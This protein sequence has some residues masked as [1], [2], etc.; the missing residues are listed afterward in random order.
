MLQAFRKV[1]EVNV[2]LK[3]NIH[4]DEEK[5]KEKEKE[6]MTETER[7]YAYW[8]CSIPMIGGIRAGQ[9]LARFGSP[10]AVYEAGT[11]GWKEL[12]SD[13]IVE[14]MDTQKKNTSPIEEYQQMEK[15]QIRL[16]LQEEEGFPQK[17]KEIPDPPY[18][19]FYKGR[20]PQEKQPAVAIIGARECSEYGRFVAA[21][22]GQHLGREKIQVISGMA[23]GIDGISQQ[24]ALAA[25][26]MSFGVLGCGVDICYPAQNRELYEQLQQSGGVLSTYAPK[27]RPL[28]AYFP[29]R[30][31]IVSGLADALI[32]IEARQ[33]SGTLITV[34]MALEQ[35]KDVYVVPGRI[36][37]RL[38]DGCNRLLTQ[39]AGIF[40]SPES[41]VE[42]FMAGWEKKQGIS[43]DSPEDTRK[44]RRKK[45]KGAKRIPPGI[46]TLEEPLRQVYGLL[47][48]MPK[49]TE[50]ILQAAWNAGSYLDISTLN[51]ALMELELSGYARQNG[52]GRYSL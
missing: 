22:L 17:L 38:S 13:S 35:G 16:V 47:D 42:E 4:K 25:G 20:L 15:L 46:D 6:R 11:T 9:L 52:Q 7:V 26:G 10:Q 8:L 24:A 36:T 33:K 27:V 39:G 43:Q 19:I 3:S 44:R 45:A 18:G 28:P 49:S 5:D 51:R 34:D 14:Y 30:N 37:D 32:V 2:C 29:P 48:T 50:D 12:L 1:L 31:R 40:L 41:F 23:R 21:E